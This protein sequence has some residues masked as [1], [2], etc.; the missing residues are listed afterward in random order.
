MLWVFTCYNGTV[1]EAP[2]QVDLST[3]ITQFKKA[4]GLT[5]WDIKSIVNNH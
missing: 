3:A 5:D 1:W 2:S 4:T